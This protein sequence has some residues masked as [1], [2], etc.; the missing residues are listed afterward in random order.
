MSGP[1]VLLTLAIV[2][3]VVGAIALP[4]GLRLLTRAQDVPR[5]QVPARAV[6]EVSVLAGTVITV[7]YPGPDGR[8]LYADVFAALRRG[9]GATPMFAGYVY[10]NP[11]DPTDVKTRPQG[12][13][14]PGWTVV[15][16]GCVA[17]G[18]GVILLLVALVGLWMQSIPVVG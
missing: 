1:V 5:V 12:K 7:E 10:V 8:P 14:G 13:V 11:N 6:T 9:L 16:V 15:I 2:L 18:A 4:V 17:L 3:V